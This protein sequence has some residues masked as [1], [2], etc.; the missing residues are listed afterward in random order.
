MSVTRSLL[1]SLA[2]AVFS[3]SPAGAQDE[4]TALRGVLGKLLPGGKIDSL[5]PTPIA[6]IYEVL[7][8]GRIYYFTKDGAYLLRGDLIDVATQH[9]LTEDT[10]RGMRLATLDRL[11]EAS[12]IVYSPANPKH[13]VTVFTDVDCPYCARFHREVPKLVEMGV[14]V[15]YAAFPRRG[16]PSENYD[17]M[18]SVW[19]AKDP[20][21]ALTD[22]KEQRPIETAVCENPVKEHFGQ[23]HSLG[24]AGTPTLI[25][26]SGE[27]VGGYV[28]FRKLVQMLENG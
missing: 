8:A 3:M 27:L 9:N 2:L 16:I 6:G 13:T 12:M 5:K 28:P 15:R 17:R 19:C 11:T 10:R 7:V 4:A 1:M 23:G 18:V 21:Q 26:D 20:T 22:A 14:K 25:L 24:V